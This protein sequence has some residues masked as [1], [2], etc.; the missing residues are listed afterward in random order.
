MSPLEHYYKKLVT[1]VSCRSDVRSVL[2]CSIIE[3]KMKSAM[4]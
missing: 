3:M 2:V 4:N 1:H